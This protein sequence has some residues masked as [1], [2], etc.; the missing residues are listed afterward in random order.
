MDGEI[1]VSDPEG[2]PDFE[3]M[4][5]RFQSKRK[6]LGIGTLTYAVFDVIQYKGE[7]VTHLLL[8]DRKQLL[9]EIITKD[10]SLVTKVKYI[11]GNGTA[12][13][14]LIKQQ[15]LEGIVM[16]QKYSHGSVNLLLP[17]IRNNLRRNKTLLEHN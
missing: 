10:T 5:S 6:N 17:A 3:A 1:I 2:K 8:L 12:F 16:K 11:E 7:S 4:M 14:D 9:N 13:F 15:A